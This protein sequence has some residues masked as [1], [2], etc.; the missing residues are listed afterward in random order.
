M[1]LFQVAWWSEMRNIYTLRCGSPKVLN[2][3]KT[4]IELFCVCATCVSVQTL[5][6]PRGSP[7]SRFHALRASS[8][9]REPIRKDGGSL[10]KDQ[11]KKKE[12]WRNT[13]PS[14]PPVSSIRR[15]SETRWSAA[16]AFLDGQSRRGT[17]IKELLLSFYPS[18]SV[19]ER[20][21][22]ERGEERRKISAWK[23]ERSCWI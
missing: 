19:C 13:A 5:T 15:T 14:C 20:M 11:R 1:D 17:Q 6:G 12:G 8:A 10:Q 9:S 22:G 23:E 16:C 7:Q 18:I 2:E 4:H 3:I 21:E